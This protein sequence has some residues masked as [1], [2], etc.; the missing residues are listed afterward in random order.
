MIA[1]THN[2]LEL[3]ANG[4]QPAFRRLF[5]RYSDRIYGVAVAYTKSHTLA[6]E[7]VQDVFLKLW[8]KR[9]SLPAVNQLESYIFILT[10]NHML[11]VLRNIARE[12]AF[13]R[14]QLLAGDEAGPPAP[15]SAIIRKQSLEILEEAL[16][17]LPAQQRA[18]FRLT[19]E[20]GISLNDAAAELGLSRNTVRNHLARAMAF[21]RAY[22]KK[23]GHAVQ[24]IF[25]LAAEIYHG[26][27]Y[28]LS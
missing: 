16:L 7:A 9:A 2:Y 11:N 1:E 25:L 15:V 3:L 23:Q 13:I 14:E 28:T 5:E 22:V 8:T 6:E 24:L 27:W 19:Q 10:R 26:H 20:Q 18:V 12:R 17:Q 21:I 4:D